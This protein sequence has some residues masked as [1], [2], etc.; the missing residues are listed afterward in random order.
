MFSVSIK[1]SRKNVI[2]K[3]SSTSI[4]YHLKIPHY[5]NQFVKIPKLSIKLEKAENGIKI[6]LEIF[7][8]K[9]KSVSKGDQTLHYIVPLNFKGSMGRAT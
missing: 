6:N 2:V 9:S 4:S 5:L 8:K 1:L 7:Y 3:I